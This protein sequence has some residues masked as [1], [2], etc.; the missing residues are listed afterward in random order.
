MKRNQTPIY[1]QSDHT[2][3]K[4]YNLLDVITVH[5]LGRE[6]NNNVQLCPT[7]YITLT[8]VEPAT[9]GQSRTLPLSY[10]VIVDVPHENITTDK[11]KEEREHIS[12]SNIYLSLELLLEL[13]YIANVLI[14]CG[15]IE[16]RS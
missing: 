6:E 8:G 14:T 13:L 4:P 9:L 2:K 10:S 7:G 3:K 16:I 5:K 11:Q 15:L 1:S 12:E